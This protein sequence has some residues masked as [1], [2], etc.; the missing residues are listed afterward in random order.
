MMVTPSPRSRHYGFQTWL[1]RP[2]GEPEHPLFP[3]RAPPEVFALIG[4]M[5]QYVIA[6]PSQR[7]TIVRLGHS[8]DAERPPMLQELADILELYPER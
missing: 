3:T 4:H 6:S 8:D 1:N 2:T 7:V 5:G